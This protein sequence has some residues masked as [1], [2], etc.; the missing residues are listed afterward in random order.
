MRA[1]CLTVYGAGMTI[2]VAVPAFFV[3]SLLAFNT[4]ARDAAASPGPLA[5]R[6]AAFKSSYVESRASAFWFCLLG[7]SA[8]LLRPLWFVG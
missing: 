6:L 3:F 8:R 7:G 1:V 4:A 5:A 2:C